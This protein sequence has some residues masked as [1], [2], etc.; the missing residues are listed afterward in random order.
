MCTFRLWI[1]KQ[2][3][4]LGFISYKV[5]DI[6]FQCKKF[7]Y[8]GKLFGKLIR[9]GTTT[10][11]SDLDQEQKHEHKEKMMF[12]YRNTGFYKRGIFPFCNI[13]CV[14]MM[15]FTIL[16]R[17]MFPFPWKKLKFTTRFHNKYSLTSRIS[18]KLKLHKIK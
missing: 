12:Y 3:P 18:F 6:C 9:R 11:N 15:Y 14:T 10:D 7:V 2:Q 1:Y 8:S 13:Y 4:K 16:F 5:T 17:G